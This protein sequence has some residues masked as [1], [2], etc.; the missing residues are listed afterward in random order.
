M[1][2]SSESAKSFG[3]TRSRQRRRR[4]K[5]VSIDDSSDICRIAVRIPP[6]WPDDPEVWFAQVEAQ[7]ANANITSDATKFNYVIGNLEHQYSKQV[8]D[9]FLAPP[10]QNKYEKLKHELI[11]RLTASHEKRVKQLL[12]H[13][14]L[15]DRKP[16]QFLRHL[17]SLAG[18]SVPEDFLR[19]IWSSRLP[20]NVQTLLASQPHTSLEELADL[21][22]RVQDIVTPC[23]VAASS[24]PGPSMAEMANEIAELKKAVRDLTTQLN[25]R[26][27]SQSRS[28]QQQRQRSRQRSQSSHRKY[29]L[30]FYHSKYGANARKCIKPCDYE[31][32]ENPKGSR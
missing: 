30:C 22:D 27:R 24:A 8:R 6:F 15:G 18:P 12:M 11:K 16:S 23:Q 21:A 9:I 17:Q 2:D 5:C 25:R 14:E 13:E 19:I 20:S 32:S 10:E 7:F 1:S 4:A 26:P 29:P 28:S 3:S 31:K